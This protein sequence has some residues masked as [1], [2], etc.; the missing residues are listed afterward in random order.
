MIADKE[1]ASSMIN[2]PE[3][4]PFELNLRVAKSIKSFYRV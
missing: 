4:I 2:V 1:M 3:E